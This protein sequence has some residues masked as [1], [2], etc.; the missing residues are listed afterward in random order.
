MRWHTTLLRFFVLLA[1]VIVVASV[2]AAAVLPEDTRLIN[3]QGL[4]VV[5]KT[6][7]KKTSETCNRLAFEPRA[8]GGPFILLENSVLEEIEKTAPVGTGIEVRVRG[9]LTAY[10][11]RNYLLL[12]SARVVSR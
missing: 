8:S 7:D 10:K 5:V 6:T 4:L 12:T 1:C 3:W 9:T 2:V 11:G